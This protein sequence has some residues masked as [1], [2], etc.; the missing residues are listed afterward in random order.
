MVYKALLKK[1]SLSVKTNEAGPQ[2]DYAN[3]VAF[4]VLFMAMIHDLSLYFIDCLYTVSWHV[5][6]VGLNSK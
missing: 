2:E 1:D 4:M 6:L 3:Y 5:T